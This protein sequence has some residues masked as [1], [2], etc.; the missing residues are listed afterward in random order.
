MVREKCRPAC[1]ADLWPSLFSDLPRT[2]IEMGI[3]APH[4]EDP[5]E[6]AWKPTSVPC[7]QGQRPLHLVQSAADVKPAEWCC[8]QGCFPPGYSIPGLGP[9]PDHSCISWAKLHI[10]TLILLPLQHWGKFLNLSEPQYFHS[11]KG[12][13]ANGWTGES[14]AGG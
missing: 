4:R 11:G 3:G 6:W 10:P 2:R 9:G 5:S 1:R 7:C 13:R 14:E 12:R 8:L